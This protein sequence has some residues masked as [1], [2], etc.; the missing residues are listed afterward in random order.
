[1][2]NARRFILVNFERLYLASINVKAT[3]VCKS[4]RTYFKIQVHQCS[5]PFHSCT[6]CEINS[7]DDNP[8]L[9]SDEVKKNLLNIVAQQ[10]V[11]P[12]S[13]AHTVL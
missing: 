5:T 10:V 1:M 12:I 13:M 9:V 8:F 11:L 6:H 4:E 3:E 2:T 7:L